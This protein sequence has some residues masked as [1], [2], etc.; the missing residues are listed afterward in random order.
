MKKSKSVFALSVASVT[1]ASAIGLA[2]PAGAEV[3]KFAGKSYDVTVRQGTFFEL[4]SVLTSTEN[5]LW[6]DSLLA[7][8]LSIA[9]GSRFGFPNPGNLPGYTYTVPLN[10]YGPIFAYRDFPGIKISVGGPGSG[11]PSSSPPIVRGWWLRQDYLTLK[12]VS[13]ANIPNYENSFL[14]LTWA[15][16]VLVSEPFVPSASV[17]EPLTILG[18]IT[19]AGF[20]IAFKR[21]KNRNKEE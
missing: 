13:I 17:P 18:S 6:G 10:Y 2:S 16:A 14:G 11:G 9:V 4:Q 8:N 21:K 15:T 1:L 5:Q 7:E 3:Y 20:G 12:E 19:A